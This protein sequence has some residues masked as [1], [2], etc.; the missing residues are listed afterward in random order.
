MSGVDPLTY[1]TTIAQASNTTDTSPPTMSTDLADLLLRMEDHDIIPS[2]LSAERHKPRDFLLHYMGCEQFFQ[3]E[4]YLAS[5]NAS[6]VKQIEAKLQRIESLRNAIFN[7][8]GDG[9]ILV[10]NLASS[11]KA[12]KATR[13]FQEGIKRVRQLRTMHFAVNGAAQKEV[14][15]LVRARDYNPDLDTNAYL[16][17]FRNGRPVRDIA[18][19]RFHEQFPSY[20][21]SIHDLMYRMEEESPL[22]YASPSPVS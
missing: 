8:M 15:S 18:D 11:L 3:R 7:D 10:Q 5:L 17:R 20:R 13:E 6:Q 16:I 1:T 14:D 4:E 9:H 19:S 2:C 22:K 12:W 21:I